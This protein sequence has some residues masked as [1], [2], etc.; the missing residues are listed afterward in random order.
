L[1]CSLYIRASVA[2]CLRMNS[3]IVFTRLFGF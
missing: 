2:S 3:L 1:G